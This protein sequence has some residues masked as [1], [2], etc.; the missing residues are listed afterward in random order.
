LSAVEQFLA[1]LA[2]VQTDLENP[3]VFNDVRGL[4]AAIQAVIGHLRDLH[5]ADLVKPTP[6]DLHSAEPAPPEVEQPR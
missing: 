3:A 5:S 2:A 6:P 1:G 4:T